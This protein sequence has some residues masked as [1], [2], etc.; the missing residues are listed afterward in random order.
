MTINA[1]TKSQIKSIRASAGL[2]Q[3]EFSALVGVPRRTFEDWESGRRTPAEYL[4][5]LLEFYVDNYKQ[6][7]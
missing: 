4:I 5:R 2:T 6:I 7:K 1:D 3:K